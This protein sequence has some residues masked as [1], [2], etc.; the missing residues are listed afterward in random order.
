MVKKISGSWSPEVLNKEF[1]G[2]GLQFIN[3]VLLQVRESE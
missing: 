1:D 2:D 3:K